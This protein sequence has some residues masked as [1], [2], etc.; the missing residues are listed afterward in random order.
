M[1][2]CIE[3]NRL[4]HS[5]GLDHNPNHRARREVIGPHSETLQIAALS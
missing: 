2:F 3:A 1:R 5:A 4:R